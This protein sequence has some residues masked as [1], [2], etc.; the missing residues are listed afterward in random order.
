MMPQKPRKE[1][2]PNAARNYYSHVVA[3]I[4]V[5]TH[6]STAAY[7]D[8]NN[9]GNSKGGKA[10]KEAKTYR[11][12]PHNRLGPIDGEKFLKFYGGFHYRTEIFR[13]REK[14]AKFAINKALGDD[15]ENKFIKTG[16]IMKNQSITVGSMG[17]EEVAHAITTAVLSEVQQDVDAEHAPI[18]LVQD[19]SAAAQ[20]IFASSTNCLGPPINPCVQYLRME[21]C[22]DYGRN[23]SSMWKSPLIP[24]LD[25]AEG[26]RGLLDHQVTGIVWLLSRMLGDLPRLSYV[27]PTTKERTTNIETAAD[28]KNRDRLKGP[29]Y[30]GGILADSMGLGKTLITVA[31]IQ[32]MVSQRLNAVHNADGKEKYRP[33]LLLTP[34]MTV[35]NQWIEDISQVIDPT[36]IRHIIVSGNI[37]HEVTQQGRE[38]RLDRERFKKWPDDLSYMWDEDD[39]RA[40]QA[41][42]VVPMETWAAR[43]VVDEGGKWTSGFSKTGR[44]FS[45]VIVDEAYKVKNT[46]TK[47]WQ[48]VYH[49]HRQHTLLITATPVMN[50]LSDLFG[51]ARLLWTAPEQYLKKNPKEWAEIEVAFKKLGDLTRLD[52]TEPSHDYRLLAGR[53]ALLYKLVYKAKNDKEADIRLTRKYLGYFESLAMLRRSSTSHIYAKWGKVDPV[54]LEGLFPRVENFTIDI[55]LGAEYDQAYQAEHSHILINYLKCIRAWS[56]K[57]AP[58]MTELQKKDI[59]KPIIPCHR[60]FQLA[61][62]S[63]DVYDIDQLMRE[64]GKQTLAQDIAFMR[65]TKINLLWLT[66]LLLAPHAERPDT[67]VKTLRLAIA[68]SPILQ[69]VLYYIRQNILTRDKNEKIRK[70]FIVEHNLMVA[71][72]YELV[73]QFLGFECRCMHAGLSNDERQ[74]LIDSFNSDDWESCQ[75]LIQNYTVGFAGTNLHRNCSRV[76]VTSQSYSLQVQSQ[77]IHRVIRVGQTAD[78]EVSRIMLR[79]S[80]HAFLESRQI[81]KAL[82]ELGGRAKGTGEQILVQILNLFQHEVI[83]AWHS[84]EGQMLR[85]NKN[86]LHDGC[87]EIIEKQ[88]RDEQEAKRAKIEEE[89][90][91]N[92]LEKESIK[93]RV[94]KDM[95]PED[96]FVAE[97]SDSE[98]EDETPTADD[99]PNSK[100]RKHEVDTSLGRDG[101]LGWYNDGFDDNVAFLYRHTRNEYYRE[102]VNLPQSSKSYLSHE[103]NNLRRLLSFASDENGNLSTE[104][105]KAAD[106][107]DAAVLERA[108]EL[109]LRVRLGTQQI[110]MLPFPIIDLSRAPL[111]RRNEIHRVLAMMQATD[112]EVDPRPELVTKAK[113]EKIPREGL[114]DFD[115]GKSVAEIER[116]LKYQA[117]YGELPRAGMSDGG[118]QSIPSIENGDAFDAEGEGVEEPEEGASGEGFG[119]V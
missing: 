84:K 79:N 111:A 59:R 77:A 15:F 94:A 68:R 48:S 42:L 101:R 22:G 88:E 8:A 93:E 47:I 32:L 28:S 21:K 115:A 44:K 6:A 16:E 66:P 110:T 26:R 119:R 64:C 33:I 43:T 19:A 56:G 117:D 54:S 13:D 53:P 36:V 61:S 85:E 29:K 86:L 14:F 83:A 72:Y 57:I 76:L 45:L 108:L 46:S 62:A 65:A 27:N 74:E 25:G 10:P 11:W 37:Q 112:Q 100:K 109:T 73:L 50:T 92:A 60:L 55:S 5:S 30:F 1:V 107:Q 104:A 116:D 17:H 69:Y 87:L 96:M 40:A 113:K 12:N 97:D 81:E 118:Y 78:V 67:H 51:L 41:I 39:P 102:F 99:N 106:L 89:G 114:K 105:W 98:P 20:S 24:N 71:Y 63:L 75:I 90:A 34:N 52:K 23:K 3:N 31:L 7:N 95:S 91:L 58:G 38:I 9:F 18:N 70:L 103:K 82:P 49:L 35:S 4:F 2:G 80:F